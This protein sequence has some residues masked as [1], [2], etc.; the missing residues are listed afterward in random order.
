MGLST[1]LYR[2]SLLSTDSVVLLPR[3]LCLCFALR[4]RRFLLVLMCFSHVSFLK[5]HVQ[6]FPFVWGEEVEQRC[7]FALSDRFGCIGRM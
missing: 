2:R 6:V 4:L 7:P 5:I 3:S 1:A